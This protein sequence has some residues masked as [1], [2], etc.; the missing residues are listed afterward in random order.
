MNNLLPF[1]ILILF[2][3]IQRVVE[4]FIAKSNEKWLKRQGAIEF[5]NKHYKYL[6]FMHLLFFV[7]LSTEK[8]L[9]NRGLSAVWPIF[10]AVFMLAQFMRGW[11]ISSLGK[12]W[13]TKILVLKHAQVVRKGPY[14]LLKHPNYFVVTTEL[15]VVP[16]LFNAFYTALLFTIFNFMILSIRIPEEEKAL[17][18]YTEYDEVF[19]GCHRFIPRIVK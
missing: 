3:A 14:R 10:L 4:L 18:M 12:Y 8:V 19:R 6:V 11:A 1:V 2:I 7:A 9:L 16:L 13:N 17:S 5:G 15:L